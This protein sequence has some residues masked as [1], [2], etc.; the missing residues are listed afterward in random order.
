MKRSAKTRPDAAPAATHSAGAE[1]VVLDVTDVLAGQRLDRALAAALPDMSRTRVQAAIEAGRVTVTGAHA[2][3][4]PLREGGMRIE[5]AP[6]SH[7][8]RQSESPGERAAPAE[9]LRI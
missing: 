6:A 5:R 8:D 3:S 1:P 4:S 9:A 7:A 2:K